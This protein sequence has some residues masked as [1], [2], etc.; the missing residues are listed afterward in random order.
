[1]FN[2]DLSISLSHGSST[3]QHSPKQSRKDKK[4]SRRSTASPGRKDNGSAGR[5]SVASKLKA[6][7]EKIDAR[8]KKL[9]EGKD[10]YQ[11][12]A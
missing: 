9:L 5:E 7:K 1:L 11:I 12:D 8:N 2:L 3:P 4:M 10:A 6:K